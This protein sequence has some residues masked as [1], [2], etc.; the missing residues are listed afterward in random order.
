[1]TSQK[2]A[3]KEITEG[4]CG[5]GHLNSFLAWVGGD[6][7]KNFPNIQMPGGCLGGGGG[8]GGGGGMLKLRFDWYI[9]KLIQKKLTNKWFPSKNV[10][11]IL[12]DP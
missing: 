1:M 11:I 5:W 6:L 8:G 3:A 12:L 4:T 10:L 2:T 7:N 9:T